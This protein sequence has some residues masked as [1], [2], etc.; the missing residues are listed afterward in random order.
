VICE[1]LSLCYGCHE[2]YER[3]V[4]RES[5]GRAGAVDRVDLVGIAGNRRGNDAENQFSMV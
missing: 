2:H 1:D 4:E 5:G 3:N